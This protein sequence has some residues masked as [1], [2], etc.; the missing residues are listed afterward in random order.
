MQQA[1]TSAAMLEAMLQG[2]KE[3]EV[4]RGLWLT[5]RNGL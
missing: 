3:G 5:N 2:A 1:M 4:A